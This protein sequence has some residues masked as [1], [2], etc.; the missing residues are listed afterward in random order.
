MSCC[1]TSATRTSGG[2]GGGGAEGPHPIV[3]T[4]H[5][6]QS[7]PAGDTNLCRE[8]GRSPKR[9]TSGRGPLRNTRWCLAPARAGPKRR[10]STERWSC[11]RDGSRGGETRLRFLP[12][13]DLLRAR[14]SSRFFLDKLE[15]VSERICA[16]RPRQYRV[17]GGQA[18]RS[19]RGPPVAA[20]G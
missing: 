18:V 9:R 10:G 15:E 2:S 1:L 13:A 3:A 11:E 20:S 4:T 14:P 5:A 16:I 8:Y 6:S 12:C 19:Q 7:A 17:K